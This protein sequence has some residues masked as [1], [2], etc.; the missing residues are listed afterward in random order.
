MNNIAHPTILE[1]NTKNFYHNV[2]EI[3]KYLNNNNIEIM[4][5]MKANAYGTYL[6]TKLDILNMFNIIG[7]SCPKEGAFLRNIGYKKEIFILNQP[8][9]SDIDNIINYNLTIGISSLQFIKQISKKK[10]EVK[11]HIEIDTG[12]G[13]TGIKPNDIINFI[14]NIKKYKNITIE[15]I[16]SH[17]S[18]ADNDETYTNEQINIFDKTVKLAKKIV[19]FK[20]IHL[21]AS[22][23]ILNY[24][25]ANYNLVRP[26]LILY[27]YPSNKDT[28]NKINI[29]PVCV[30]KSKITYLKEVPKN[31]S[32]SYGRTFITNKNTKI[33][34]IPI[35][36]ADGYKRCLSNK[37]NVL[38]NN[39]LA[40]II[41]TICMDSLMV[42]VTNINNVKLNDIVY[43]WD[44]KNIT[45]D[46]IANITNT[47]NYEILTSINERVTRIFK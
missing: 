18:S 37:G 29:K 5:I 32:I 25:Q 35:G 6:N 33:A 41:G 15:G 38:I 34:T 14:N 17:L 30:L 9:T 8:A 43:L 13:R 4:P 2:N 40:P 36:Y 10:K 12:M 27:G 42:D 45:V 16:Y 28:L 22:N 1:I 24:P 39:K 11:I 47:I 3:K 26:G 7:V 20:Y 31:T 23:G 46:D 21:N 44:N 19:D